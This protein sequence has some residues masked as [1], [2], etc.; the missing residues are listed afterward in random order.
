MGEYDGGD[1]CKDTKKTYCTKCKCL[2]PNY[3]PPKEPACGNPKYK[4]DG[5]CD[6][7]NN[8]ASC[9]YDG[10]DCCK[11][12]KK[13][14]CTKCK[15]LDPNY[16]PPPTTTT[17]PSACGAKK[18]KGDGNCDDNGGDCCEQ[19]LGK[20]VKRNYCQKCECID[21]KN[22]C[23]L[24]K[25]KCGGPQHKGDGHCDDYNNN[26]GCDYDG[27]DCCAA[28]VKNGKVLKDYCNDCSCKDPKYATKKK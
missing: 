1:C 3:K 22:Q 18:Y 28:S 21:P 16:K 6:D 23:V 12:T 15:C 14:Y 9:D 8:K 24:K 27:G 17:K 19:S 5:N 26:C 4:G 25:N 20:P 10:G 7:N 13:L 11:D 2:D